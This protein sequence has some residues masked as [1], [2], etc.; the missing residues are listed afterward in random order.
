MCCYI[1]NQHDKLVARVVSVTTHY[2][3]NAFPN[4]QNAINAIPF[5]TNRFTLRSPNVAAF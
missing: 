2:D 1:L 3:L 5:H 4:T